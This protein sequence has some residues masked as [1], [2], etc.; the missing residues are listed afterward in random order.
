MAFRPVLLLEPEAWEQRRERR[1]KSF[2]W[3]GYSDLA[4]ASSD[5]MLS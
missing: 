4:K 1:H 3:K 5:L 2:V